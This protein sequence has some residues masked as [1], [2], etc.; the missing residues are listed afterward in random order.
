MDIYWIP[1]VCHVMGEALGDNG[2]KDS[3]LS[4]SLN[5][6]FIHAAFPLAAIFGVYSKLS[7]VPKDIII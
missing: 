2:E 5:L 7:K 6:V 3:L 1:A 4:Q